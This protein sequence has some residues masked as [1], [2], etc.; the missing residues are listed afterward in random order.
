[1]YDSAHLICMSLRFVT[2][3]RNVFIPLTN[4][5]RN[6]C[7]YCGFRRDISHPEAILLSPKEVR[8]IL[9]RGSMA[10]CCEALFTFGE[11][12]EEVEGFMSMLNDFGYDDIIDYL[13]DL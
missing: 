11:R 10:G 5:C 4:I 7:G 1:M 9:D 3:S 8:D 2:F 12:P 13:L 6:R